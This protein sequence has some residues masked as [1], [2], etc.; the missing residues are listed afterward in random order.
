M[1]PRPR[2]SNPDVVRLRRPVL[3]PLSAAQPHS[4]PQQL[5]AARPLSA[6]QPP[7]ALKPLSAAHLQNPNSA[8]R[9]GSLHGSGSSRS[10]SGRSPYVPTKPTSSRCWNGHWTTC[11]T[12]A[13]PNG[14]QPGGRSSRRRGGVR[15]ITRVRL[16]ATGMCATSPCSTGATRPTSNHTGQPSGPVTSRSRFETPSSDGTVDSARTSGRPG[17]GAPHACSFSTTTSNRLRWAVRTPRRTCDCSAGSTTDVANGSQDVDIQI[18]CTHETGSDGATRCRPRNRLP[19]SNRPSR[20]ATDSDRARRSRRTACADRARLSRRAACAADR[21]P[22]YRR[23][24]HTYRLR[25]TTFRL[26]ATFPDR[27][28]SR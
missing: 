14:V 22:S 21:G 8:T 28:S 12:A 11:S 3:Q 1:R 9:S 25:T 27:R 10:S 26:A 15:M 13:T 2:T 19:R 18:E 23:K 4:A 7:S 17:F 16:F 24:G 20:R 5:S 6:L